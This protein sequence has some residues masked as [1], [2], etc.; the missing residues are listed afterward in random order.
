MSST[1]PGVFAKK[2]GGREA[3]VVENRRM[4]NFGTDP[5][6]LPDA[7]YNCNTFT[8]QCS[9]LGTVLFRVYVGRITVNLFYILV[10][11]VNLLKMER[12]LHWQLD[13]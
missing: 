12:S 2:R 5:H 6:P 10:L 1:V 8:R 7:M 11:I 4:P 13:L 3:S 9:L